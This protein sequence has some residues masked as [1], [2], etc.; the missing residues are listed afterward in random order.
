[1]QITD[2]KRTP[3]PRPFALEERARQGA[4]SLHW[5]DNVKG[6]LERLIF[7]RGVMATVGGAA[8]AA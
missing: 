8:R 4:I 3:N 2:D 6:G 7:A 5:L 1:M